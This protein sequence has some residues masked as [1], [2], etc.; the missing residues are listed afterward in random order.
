[1]SEQND[2]QIVLLKEIAKWVRFNGFNQV[3]DVLRTTL[4]N[5]KKILAYDLSDG[6]TTSTVIAQK[7]GINQQKITVLWKEWLTLGLGESISVSGGSRFKSSFDL[8][9][10]DIQIPEVKQTTPQPSEEPQ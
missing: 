9:M 10:F 4:D 2:E 3:K 7:T 8:K 6:K 1:M 5:D